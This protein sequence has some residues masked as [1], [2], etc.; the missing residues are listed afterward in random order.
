MKRIKQTLKN[1][2]YRIA[3][4]HIWEHPFR[5]TG[6]DGYVPDPEIK[7]TGNLDYYTQK[8]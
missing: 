1:K 4:S 8:G 5:L 6:G 3:L 2:Y 7:M